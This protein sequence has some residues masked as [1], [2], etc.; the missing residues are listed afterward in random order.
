MAE[1]KKY[2]AHGIT[3]GDIHTWRD[4]R[5]VPTSRP[6]FNPPDPKIVMIDIPGSDD[7]VDMTETLTGQVHYNR[8][9]GSWEFLV[10]N[11][12]AWSEVYSMILDYLHGQNMKAILDDD[13]Q[14][15]Y[16]S[17][18]SVN[19]WKSDPM[20]SKIVIDYNAD[21]YKYEIF[22]SLEPWLWDPFNFNTGIIREYGDLK[23]DGELELTIVGTRKPV[24]PAITVSNEGFATMRVYFNNSLTPIE[25]TAGTTSRVLN[26][27]IKEGLNT[28]R[29]VGHGS[30]SVDYRGGRL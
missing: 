7:V 11:K 28:I 14:F 17:R 26:I 23:V 4:W 22:S 5:I 19:E 25:L 1:Y 8:R 15:Y 2:V 3:L 13:P 12:S 10:Q 30:V 24:V 20:N 21:P 18:F 29:F 16:Q 9:K 27:V 6:V